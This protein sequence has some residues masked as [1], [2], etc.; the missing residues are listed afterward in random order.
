MMT[1]I[2]KLLIPLTD[3]PHM[4]Y[5]A[6]LEEAIVLLN[7]AHESG[8]H[9][10]LV[11][12][13]FYKLLGMLDGR[14]IL[15]VINPKF[16]KL[17]PDKVSSKWNDIINSANDNQFKKPIKDFISPFNMM[18]ESTDHILKVAYLLLQHNLDI[19]PVKEAGKVL[20]VVRMHDIFHKI[21]GSIL[22]SEK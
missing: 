14:E 11:F 10:V 17:S 19:I 1:I 18:V 2:K 6:T 4:P 13:E 3:Y 9:T 8:Y 7:F 22:Q 16:K 21:T 15:R 20:G 12:D 5:W